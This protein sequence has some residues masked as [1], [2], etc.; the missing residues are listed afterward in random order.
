MASAASAYG[1]AKVAPAHPR[2]ILSALEFNLL[3]EVQQQYF[4]STD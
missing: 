2:V 3:G 4:L 1:A